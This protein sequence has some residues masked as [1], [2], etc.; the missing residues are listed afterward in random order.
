M[1]AGMKICFL[2]IMMCLLLAGPALAASPLPH[3]CTLKNQVLC[4]KWYD[5]TVYGDTIEWDK[6]YGGIARCTILDERQ[7]SNRIYSVLKCT[8]YQHTLPRTCAEALAWRAQG[9]EPARC[10]DPVGGKGH[11]YTIEK[12]EFWILSVRP[13]K[14]MT[15]YKNGIQYSYRSDPSILCMAAPYN[16]NHDQTLALDNFDKENGCRGIS[17]VTGRDHVTPP[18]FP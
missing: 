7:A 4:G 13:T 17:G 3:P 14:F 1:L 2:C 16:D 5:F 9:R 10:I 11:A 6:K 18:V 12:P 8:T 15:V